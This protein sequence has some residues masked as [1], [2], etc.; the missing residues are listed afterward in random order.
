M[1]ELARLPGAYHRLL[2]AYPRW[3]RRERGD[4]I[5]TTLV[6]AA[7]QGG[8]VRFNIQDALDLLIGG[9]RCRLRLP[10]GRAVRVVAMIA[11]VFVGVTAAAAAGLA[12]WRSV[13]TVPTGAQATNA[14]DIALPLQDRDIAVY[15]DPLIL[16]DGK[17]DLGSA[18]L[19]PGADPSTSRIVLSYRVAPEAV[20]TLMDQARR[21]LAQAGFRMA[22]QQGGPFNEYKDESIVDKVYSA[23]FWAMKDDLILQMNGVG[24][25]I[26]DAPAI[27]ISV[28][29][30]AS[31]WVTVGAAAAMLVGGFTGWLLTG[32]AV[33]GYLGHGP[34]AKAL[35]LL[36]GLP[37]LFSAGLVGFLALATC[38]WLALVQGWNAQDSLA[39]AAT[40]SGAPILT[41]VALASLAVCG[42]VAGLAPRTKR[43]A[44]P[45]DQYTD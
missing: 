22:P 37:G 39:P 33:R 32:W 16:N 2:W 19:P 27:Q 28:H 4:E 26:G 11:A 10:T 44:L 7:P 31:D 20:P 17:G 6:D 12:I 36:A 45:S 41:V 42:L 1:N 23:S 34:W 38:L 5:L 40:V 8:Y 13:A 25:P 15:N 35:L 9:I 18:V 21:R 14:A 29:R 24:G 43:T 3:Y 30:Q